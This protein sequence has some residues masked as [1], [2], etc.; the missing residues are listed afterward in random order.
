MQWFISHSSALE[1][2]RRTQAED[3]LSRKRSRAAKVP[4][5]TGAVRELRKSGVLNLSTPLHVLARSVGVRKNLGDLH[6][7][8]SSGQFPAG[9]FIPVTPELIV[10][11]PELCFLQMASE[12]PLIE[13]VVLGYE[14]CGGYRLNKQS[15]PRQGFR[16]DRPLTDV[17]KLSA[18]LER[19]TGLKG[20]KNAVRAL[21]F[22]ADNAASPME[23][24]LCLL[25]TLPYRLGGYGFPKPRLNCHIRLEI[26]SQ[27]ARSRTRAGL[28][29]QY[30]GDLYWPDEQVDVEYDSDAWHSTHGR[31]AQDIRRRNALTA[32]GV[33]ELTVTRA[34][35]MHTGEFREMAE[36]L[37]SLLGKRLKCSGP[38]F[39]ARHQALRARLLP[40]ISA[41]R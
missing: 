25:L 40:G 34:Q 19:A 36:E 18:Y 31:A 2:W 26:D 1:F 41:D 27:K 7:H 35:V 28:P 6:R 10:C 8:I 37:S 38:E 16:D 11:S 24:V 39:A 17:A 30:C 21:R 32:A 12:L 9:S 22:I 20:R 4:A 15:A 33:T 3:A 5:R 14:F 13:L 23:T 29:R